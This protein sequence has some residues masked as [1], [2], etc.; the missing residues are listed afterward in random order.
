MTPSGFFCL[1]VSLFV[2]KVDFIFLWICICVGIF[3]K[4]ILHECVCPCK[5]GEGV[6]FLG[7]GDKLSHI[8]V[9]NQTQDLFLFCFIFC[10][11]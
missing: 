6:K 3:F 10:S 1:F 7:A 9:G 11:C 4:Y 2:F 5:P 8:G